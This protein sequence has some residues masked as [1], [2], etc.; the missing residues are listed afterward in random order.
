MDEAT[1]GLDPVARVQLR[2]SLQR[3]AE[4]RT[5]LLSTHLVE[6]VVQL[7]DRI[8]VLRDGRVAYQGS[9]M[10]LAATVASRDVPALASPLEA[11]YEQLLTAGP[12]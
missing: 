10:E 5:V 11:A 4:G 9:P 8:I 2:R 1:V 3:I 7:C 12:P 6:D